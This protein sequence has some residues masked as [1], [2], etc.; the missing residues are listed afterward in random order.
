MPKLERVP[1]DQSLQEGGVSS[2]IPDDAK[3]PAVLKTTPG[4]YYFDGQSQNIRPEIL[5]KMRLISSGRY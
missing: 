1:I 5:E 3:L 4:D 2:P